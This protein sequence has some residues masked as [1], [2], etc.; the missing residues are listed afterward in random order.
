MP[1]IRSRAAQFLL[2][3][4]TEADHM[5]NYGGSH[6][7][8]TLAPIKLARCPS[9]PNVKRVTIAEFAHPLHDLLFAV[10]SFLCRA[11]LPPDFECLDL[12]PLASK[13]SNS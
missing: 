1:K 3:F 6:G 2:N 8:V 5:Q 12:Q 7:Q 4:A 9:V 10:V 13:L 11:A